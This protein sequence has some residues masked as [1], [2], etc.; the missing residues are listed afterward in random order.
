[1]IDWSAIE[2][3]TRSFNEDGGGYVNN[4]SAHV[5]SVLDRLPYYYE[6]VWHDQPHYIEV[7]GRE[8]RDTQHPRAGV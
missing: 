8:G 4:P 2:D 5:E 1:M 6:D 3:P 7:W